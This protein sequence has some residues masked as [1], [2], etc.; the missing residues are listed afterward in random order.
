MF[1]HQLSANIAL[2]VTL[3]LIFSAPFVF[4]IFRSLW[5]QRE[6][7][8]FVRPPSQIANEHQLDQ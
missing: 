1:V 7:R 5:R 8:L 6:E 3:L 2:N 4:V